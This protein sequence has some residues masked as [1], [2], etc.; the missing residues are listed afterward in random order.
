MEDSSVTPA[1]MPVTAEPPTSEA[2]LT[3]RVTFADLFL[4]N[5]DGSI[6][7][8][9]VIEINGFTLGPGI[10]I[11]PK[12]PVGGIDLFDYLNKDFAAVIEQGRYK[13]VGYYD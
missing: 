5:P 11:R 6:S 8:K 7:P 1:A 9:A 2:H 3:E 4:T 10:S 13:L 12:T